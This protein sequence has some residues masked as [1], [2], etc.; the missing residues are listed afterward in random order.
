[1]GNYN[2]KFYGEDG[3]TPIKEFNFKRQ[4]IDTLYNTFQDEG[5]D[6][7]FRQLFEEILEI[8]EEEYEKVLKSTIN[9]DLKQATS[10][11]MFANKT[12]TRK[13]SKF[14]FDV[15]PDDKNAY[16]KFHSVNG[17]VFTVEETF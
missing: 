3:V 9:E 13:T 8:F 16:I 7:L 11:A 2:V 5:V 1:M 10:Q 15:V 17:I 14:T 12:Y 4:Y 6:K